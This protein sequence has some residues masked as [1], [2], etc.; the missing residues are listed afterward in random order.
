MNAATANPQRRGR[1]LARRIVPPLA[2]LGVLATSACGSMNDSGSGGAAAGSGSGGKTVVRG[3]IAN[4][5]DALWTTIAC[6][7]TKEAKARGIDFKWYAGKTTDATELNTNFNAANLDKPAGLIVDAPQ[8]DQFAGQ[9]SKLM[10]KGVPVASSLP[11][12]PASYVSVASAQNP[13]QAM[14]DLTNGIMKGG[15]SVFTVGGSAAVPILQD[16]FMPLLNSLKKMGGVNVLPVQYTD[17]DPNKTQTQVNSA[18]LA[19]KDLKLVVASTGP[20]GQGA[21]AAL[22]ASGRTDV[23]IIAFDAVPAEVQA[24]KDGTITALGAQPAEAV[25]RAQVAHLADYLK[26]N[27]GSTAAVAPL[28]LDPLPM[29]L[30]TKENLSDPAMA[31]YIYKATCDA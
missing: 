29:G 17:F 27:E 25:G 1:R 2:L 12:K 14:I 5:S 4:T 19:H 13:P 24:L 9:I 6:G 30:L 23:K 3:V 16:R 21:A 8:I 26:K 18:V 20:E 31:G 11:V 28:S 7:A 15:G 10:A 22:K